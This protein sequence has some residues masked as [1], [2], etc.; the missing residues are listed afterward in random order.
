MT[1]SIPIRKHLVQ[2]HET[3]VLHLY[4]YIDYIKYIMNIVYTIHYTGIR[5]NTVLY[6]FFDKI[7]VLITLS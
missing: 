7:L 1:R 4:L 3:A 5:R 6:S 2:F